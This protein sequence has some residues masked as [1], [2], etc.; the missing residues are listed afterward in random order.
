MDIYSTCKDYTLEQLAH[1]SNSSLTVLN[2]NI[3]SLRT[4]FSNLESIINRCVKPIDIIC[5]TE[6]FIY[7][8]ETSFFQ[9]EHYV[10]LG[11]Q[12]PTRC[13]GVGV[14]LRC[15]IAEDIG[16]REAVL[17]G[18]EAI[19]LSLSGGAVSMFKNGLTLSIIYRQ[20]S[21]DVDDFLHDLD[22]YLNTFQSSSNHILVG[23]ININTLEE[24]RVSSEYLNILSNFNY[25]NL[26]TIPTRINNCLDHINVNF[27]SK[28]L[29]AGTIS[30]VLSDHLPTFINIE[31]PS[32]YLNLKL[33]G[34]IIKAR[35]YKQFNAERF[36]ENLKQIDWMETVL[37]EHDANKM[38]DNFIYKFRKICDHHAPIKELKIKQSISSCR[39]SWLNAEIL[40][41]IRKKDYL[42]RQTL[43]SPLN[44]KLKGKFKAM[45][46][47]VTQ[48]VR[49]AKTEHYK[50]LIKMS[51]NIKHLWKI[52]NKEVGKSS[53][54]IPSPKVIVSENS[55][56]TEEITN[57]KE[58][59]NS[60]NKYFTE[61]GPSLAKSF[62]DNFSENSG[63]TFVSTPIFSFTPVLC[64]EVICLLKELN[65]AKATGLDSIPAKMI[66]IATPVIAKPFTHIINTSLE[67]GVVPSS[68]KIAK[69]MPLFKKGSTKFCSNYRPISILSVFSKVLEKAINKQI[70]THLENNKIL[71][72]MQFGFRKNKSTSSALIELTNN[73]LKAFNDGKCVL[74]VFL[75]FSKAFD[76]L[77][78]KI[79][80]R[81][82]HNL[83]FNELA[84]NWIINFLTNRKQLTIINE[85]YSEPLY[86]KCGVPQGSVLGPTLFLIYIN[87]LT[88]ITTLFSPILYADDTNLFLE[89]ANLNEL[90]PEINN[91]LCLIQNWCEQNK[92]T[93]NVEKTNFVILKKF[94]NK[95]KFE[96]DSIKMFGKTLTQK[97]TIKFLGVHLDCHLNWKT[98]INNLLTQLRPSTGLLYRCSQYLPRNVLLLIYNSFIH[99]R[100]TYCIEAWGNAPS[101]HLNKILIFQKRLLRIIFKQSRLAH[102]KPLFQKSFIL[103]IYNLYQY[104]ILIQ[105]HTT[106][107]SHESS[108]NHHYNTR[109]STFNLNLPKSRSA[110]GHRRV[111][112][113]I[114]ALWNLLPERIRSLRS[115]TAFGHA[116]K[117]RLLFE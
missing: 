47:K 115:E 72:D 102:T 41:M 55:D 23:D 86:L 20:P 73:V 68:M 82:L 83:N 58:I 10:F 64:S 32:Q 29:S 12:R 66:K 116:L 106:F 93:I 11:I 104:R 78:F 99:S 13:G 111:S 30:T 74:G 61:I 92:L 69:V 51:N 40:Q 54:T 62:S 85:T 97:D 26:I 91:E 4:H 38:Y 56:N 19:T 94:Q 105:S 1:F 39:K 7:D 114:S 80:K 76:T 21:A 9:L 109:C 6:T 88:Q 34:K 31:N 77:D 75:D 5:L 17:A 65:I 63:P 22:L 45:R 87:D 84:V 44:L 42:Y 37:A 25:T 36:L 35:D 110:C 60:F 108:R 117:R 43:N 28:I 96:T 79:L 107:Y 48:M 16:W 70:M 71:T 24:N 98:H 15:G 89:S 14:Y 50:N 103:N 67:S 46:N 3:R 101:T 53:V 52:I 18:S 8:N 95:F 81:K 100:L 49:N 113:K 59:A 112:Y 2:A 33:E 90:V 27:D 57:E